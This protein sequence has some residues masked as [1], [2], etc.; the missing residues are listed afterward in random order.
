MF[1]YQNHTNENCE[2]FSLNKNTFDNAIQIIQKTGSIKGLGQYQLDTLL[3]G[4]IN[5]YDKENIK[6]SDCNEIMSSALYSNFILWLKLRNPNNEL[7]EYISCVKF[8]QVFGEK[9][10]QSRNSK[11]KCW[12]N[13]AINSKFDKINENIAN[14]LMLY[15]AT[16]PTINYITDVC[17]IDINFDKYLEK[18]NVQKWYSIEK[19]TF[20]ND[21]YEW[22]LSNDAIT[23]YYKP[24]KL[25]IKYNGEYDNLL[26]DFD[27]FSV[28]LN[29]INIVS[30]P[31]CKYITSSVV[32]T[33]NEEYKMEIN[34]SITNFPFLRKPYMNDTLLKMTSQYF[35][36]K[37]M[38]ISVLVEHIICD[39]N[40]RNKLAIV[41]QIM[42]LCDKYQCD[43]I[44][45]KTSIDLYENGTYRNEYIRGVLLTGYFDDDLQN[46]IKNVNIRINGNVALSFDKT[47]IKMIGKLIDKYTIYIPFGNTHI[48]NIHNRISYRKMD[49]F[50][51]DIEFNEINEYSKLIVYVDMF[52]LCSYKEQKIET[53]CANPQE[54]IKILCGNVC[55]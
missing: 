9:H 26:R 4:I 32:E 19:F 33:I 47:L 7:L 34:I 12:L 3:N 10:I 39:S 44:S 2:T 48:D 18:Y 50:K 43:K 15:L 41:P 40:V 38:Q 51:L 55:F 1:E 46:L 36:D 24:I 25:I 45:Q 22:R 30:Q 14:P 13:I 6:E 16:L 52:D 54:Y 42:N 37:D 49:T 53:Y 27:K 20:Q 5:Q 8:V 23:D 21:Q 29:G 17:K 28:E 31:M 11:G 35:K